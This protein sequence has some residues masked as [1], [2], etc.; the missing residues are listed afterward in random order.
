M[1][2]NESV[3]GYKAKR[4]LPEDLYYGHLWAMGWIWW[5]QSW[6]L[7]WFV[8]NLVGPP[9]NLSNLSGHLL[10]VFES[11]EL[12][13]S[14]S[15]IPRNSTGLISY[16]TKY[17]HESPY[18]TPTSTRNQ[19]L[20]WKTALIHFLE[21]TLISLKFL[22]FRTIM[23]LWQLARTSQM[24]K[25]PLLGS[26]INHNNNDNNHSFANPNTELCVGHPTSTLS[27]AFASAWALA[28]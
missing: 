11:Y 13:I 15:K 10:Q 9:T 27:W 6:N 4:E 19:G 20:P 5:V 26:N 16:I 14:V 23:V 22:M 28:K 24:L 17:Q 21:D 18:Y 7:D 1:Q 25:M 12:F 2:R 3:P 8:V